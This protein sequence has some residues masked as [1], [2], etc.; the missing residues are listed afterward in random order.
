MKQDEERLESEAAH[1]VAYGDYILQQVRAARDMNRW[2]NGT[3]LFH[4]VIDFL[5]IHYPGYELKEL[6]AENLDYELH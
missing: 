2:I 5:N 4:Y 6:D 1:L 3:D